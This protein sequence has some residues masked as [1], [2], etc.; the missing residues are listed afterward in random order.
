MG[1]SDKFI[2]I[3]FGE[4]ALDVMYDGSSKIYEAGGVSNFNTLYNLAALG[5]EAYAIGG[6]GYD[7]TDMNEC[8]EDRSAIK[9]IKAI[10]SLKHASVNTREIELIT[11]KSTNVFYIY[12]P[13]NRLS[14]D[15]DLTI[16][17]VSPITGKRTIE[18]S[19]RLNTTLPKQFENKRVI[20]IV[21]NF[22]PGTRRFINDTQKKCPESRISLDITNGKIFDGYSAEYIWSYLKTI[23]LIQCNE[24]TAK[25]LCQKLGVSAIEEIV[26]NLQTEIFTLTKGSK[27]ATF[28]YKDNGELKIIN[29]KPKRVEYPV[30]P[31]GAGDAFHTM[32]LISYCRMLYNGKKIDERYFDSAFEYANALARKVLQNKGARLKPY[33]LLKH[34][35]E[36]IKNIENRD[37]G[38]R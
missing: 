30:D 22:E 14:T 27:G 9:A 5:E 6:V 33:E 20:L 24:N 37:G 28:F 18:W 13:K 29:K 32:M 31:T 19:D 2:F 38:E 12:R 21:S 11:D 35:I 17:R 8:R 10:E 26:A 7:I 1:K 25:S 3:A 23:N 36:E 4:L 34:M 15:G 16:D